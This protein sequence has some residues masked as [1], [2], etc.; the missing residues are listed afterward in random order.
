MTSRERIRSALNH[1]IADR[2]PLDLGGGP[3]SGMAVSSVHK[4][5]VALGLCGPEDPVKVSEPFQ[6]LGEIDEPLGEALGVDVVCLGGRT[7]FMGFA[8]EGWKPWRLFDGTPVLVPEKFNTDPEPNG[9]IVQYPEGD[10]HLPPCARM[11]EG[12]FY[13]DAIVRQRPIVENELKVEDNLE[14]FAVLGDQDLEHF[15]SEAARLRETTDCAV[16]LIGVGTAFGDIAHVPA[17]GLREPKGIRDVEEWYVSLV[18]RRELVREIFTRQAEI[19][20]GNLELLWSVV[21][22]R[23]DIIYMSGTDFGTQTTQFLSVDDYLDLFQ[24]FQRKLNDWVHQH[25]TWKTFQHSCGAIE[26]LIPHF[27]DAGFDILNPVQTSAAGMDP[28]LLKDTYGERIV[29]WGGGVDTQKTL[30]FGTADE[31]RREVRERLEIFTPGGGFVFNTVHN[32]QAGVPV[33]NMLAVYET[34][35]EFG[36]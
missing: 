36:Y 33:A 3:T 29:L 12:G 7:N 23:A 26:P 31:V 14:E 9:D 11:P 28:R 22:Q 13:F 17:P 27:I 34:V 1:T 20:L 6:M 32:V 16:M 5:K 30:P 24:P 15:R 4:L 25:T 21:G 18:L 35:R 10:R 8:N 19:A 2:V